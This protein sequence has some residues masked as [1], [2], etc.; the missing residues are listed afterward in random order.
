MV[1][2]LITKETLQQLEELNQQENENIFP[3]EILLNELKNPELEQRVQSVKQIHQIAFALGEEKCRVFLIPFIQEIINQEEKEVIIGLIQV[4]PNLIV[5]IGGKGYGNLLMDII[6]TQIQKNKNQEIIQELVTSFKKLLE[7]IDKKYFE[8]ILVDYVQEILEIG[9]LDAKEIVLEIIPDIY[10]E[11]SQDIQNDFIE[12][13]EQ[14]SKDKIDMVRKALAK[15]LKVYAELLPIANE[16]KLKQI[17]KNLQFDKNDFVREQLL[18][19]LLVFVDKLEQTSIKETEYMEYFQAIA[20]DKSLKVKCS[21]LQN[22]AQICEVFEYE[23]I[24]GMNKWFDENEKENTQ[25]KV[26]MQQKIEENL[27]K[28]LEGIDKEYAFKFLEKVDDFSIF[29]EQMTP[30]LIKAVETVMTY[31][32]WRLKSNGLQILGKIIQQLKIADLND[33]LIQIFRTNMQDNVFVLRKDAVNSLV[34][35]LKNNQHKPKLIQQVQKEFEEIIINKNYLIRICYALFLQDSIEHIKKL[36]YFQT[37][38]FKSQLS[39]IL[40]DN[41]PNIQL[42][43]LNVIQNILE[44]IQE[45]DEYNQI[46]MEQENKDMDDYLE[47]SKQIEQLVFEQIQKEETQNEDSKFYVQQHI[48]QE[49]QENEKLELQKLQLK[50]NTTNIDNY[51]MTLCKKWKF[52]KQL[53][54]QLQND[55]NTEKDVYLAEKIGHLLL[56]KIGAIIFPLSFYLCSIASN[57]TLFVFFYVGIG[58]TSFTLMT[59]PIINCL[60]THFRT[61]SGKT[62]GI[63]LFAFEISNFFYYLLQLYLINPNNLEASIQI[64]QNNGDSI[65]LFDK[66]VTENY[67]LTMQ[68]TAIFVALFTIP[69]SFLIDYNDEDD[70]QFLNNNIDNQTEL[71]QNQ[72]YISKKKSIIQARNSLSLDNIILN[73]EKS[74]IHSTN[75]KQFEDKVNNEYNPHY[76]VNLVQTEQQKRQENFEDFLGVNLNNKI[77]ED[78]EEILDQIGTIT[79]D[80]QFVCQSFRQG[81]LSFPFISICIISFIWALYSLFFSFNYKVYGM[82]QLNDDF[83]LSYLGAVTA[84]FKAVANLIWGPI[85]DVYTPKQLYTFMR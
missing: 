74:L 57:F 11:M 32:K 27:I 40:F 77:Q 71:L 6:V 13:L 79:T 60:W 85:S 8:K 61:S 44:Q 69:G 26:I 46:I 66:N 62:T 50:K 39:I 3:L 45:S 9:T 7:V 83:F 59:I 68:V 24:Q 51:K 35:I 31:K 17:Y 38:Q 28:F 43:A 84:C 10:L 75:K 29:T 78:E 22:F 63:A 21:I 30:A 19:A 80:Q 76:K 23:L 58:V 48:Q 36:D 64:Q 4:L 81:L 14:L 52:I 20:N 47:T 56:I 18:K 12:I 54:Q 25:D 72:N 70:E 49:K 42:V 55:R 5:P 41:T 82:R 37:E 33:K 2:S 15:K 65:Y 34:Q 16:E 53:L 73:L 67:Q 1:D